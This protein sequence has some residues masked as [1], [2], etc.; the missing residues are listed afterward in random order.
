VESPTLT[1]SMAASA[2][3]QVR[4]CHGHR[5]WLVEHQCPSK[6]EI[7]QTAEAINVGACVDLFARTCSGAMNAGFRGSR[8]RS[9]DGVGGSR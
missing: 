6:Q 2:F 9:L 4:Y 3:V 8:S 1:A 5:I 7:R